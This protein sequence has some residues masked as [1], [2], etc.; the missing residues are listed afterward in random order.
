VAASRLPASTTGISSDGSIHRFASA[1]RAIANEHS[2]SDLRRR[3]HGPPTQL[4]DCEKLQADAGRMSSHGLLGS[5]EYHRR[6][7]QRAAASNVRA[8]PLGVFVTPDSMKGTFRHN[9]MQIVYAAILF[10][11]GSAPS[12]T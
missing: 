5:T 7:R 12:L 9:S 10:L 2:R 1:Y 11:S 3:S 6:S 4:V 8:Q